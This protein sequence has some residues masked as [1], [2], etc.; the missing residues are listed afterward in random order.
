MVIA[1]QFRVEFLHEVH[2]VDQFESGVEQGLHGIGREIDSAVVQLVVALAALVGDVVGVVLDGCSRAMVSTRGLS[3]LFVVVGRGDALVIEMVFIVVG[4]LLVV[5]QLLILDGRERRMEV[6][7]A[8]AHV[9][10][11]GRGAE[12]IHGVFTADANDGFVVDRQDLI[13]DLERR[14]RLA[15]GERGV[16]HLQSAVGLGEAVFED[17]AN[18]DT[19]FVRRAFRAQNANSESV[20]TV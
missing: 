14:M 1:E 19:R 8:K 10:G 17:F 4:G 20:A 18:V 15:S 13:A 2:Q 5:E 16:S 11:R 9:I 7:H 12:E 3:Q 6:F